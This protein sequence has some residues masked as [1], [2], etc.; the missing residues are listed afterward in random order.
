MLKFLDVLHAANRIVSARKAMDANPAPP[1]HWMGTTFEN[2]ITEEFDNAISAACDATADAGMEVEPKARALMLI[3]DDIA[4]ARIKWLQDGSMHLPTAPP[5]G[6]EQLRNNLDRLEAQLKIPDLPLPPPIA[7][8]QKVHA[9]PNQIA[10]TYGWRTE[11]GSPDVNKVFEEVEKPGTHFNPKKWVHPALRRQQEET[12]KLW[13]NRIPRERQSSHVA[14]QSEGEP[15]KSRVPS[16]DELIQVKA[17]VEQIMRLHKMTEQE[18]L[19]AAELAGVDLRER[20]IQPAN[21]TVAH[22]ERMLKD[23]QEVA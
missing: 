9:S 21:A 15:T 16:L 13:A 14:S 22:H 23:S 10:I 18:V 7:H 3:L 12:D 19:E 1:V 8:L 4:A 5:T 11:D 2:P 20:Y 6:S 17:P